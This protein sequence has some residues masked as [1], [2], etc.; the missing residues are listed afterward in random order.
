MPDLIQSAVSLC[1]PGSDPAFKAIL[2]VFPKTVEKQMSAVNTQ[3]HAAMTM[4]R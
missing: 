4:T 2:R 1:F 3:V